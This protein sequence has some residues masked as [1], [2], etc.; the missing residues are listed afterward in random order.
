MQDTLDIQP[1]KYL[2]SSREIW[3]NDCNVQSAQDSTHSDNNKQS[4]TGKSLQK[5]VQLQDS[6][7][8]CQPKVCGKTL[9][10]VKIKIKELIY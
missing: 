5:I 2:F 6:R 10:E 4:K 9:R 3:H 1:L 7:R 8:K